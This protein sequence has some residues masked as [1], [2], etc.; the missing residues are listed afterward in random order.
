MCGTPVAI[1]NGLTILSQ[2]HKLFEHTDGIMSNTLH[3]CRQVVIYI[4]MEI[5]LV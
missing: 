2:M 1:K 5:L 3:H 4:E